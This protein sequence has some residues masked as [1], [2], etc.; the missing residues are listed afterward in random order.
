MEVPENVRKTFER[1]KLEYPYYIVLAVINGRFYVYKSKAWWDKK[2]KKVRSKKEYLGRI[3]ETGEFIKRVVVKAV[4]QPVVTSVP[5]YDFDKI[6]ESILMYLSMNCRI[7]LSA[8][9]NKLGVTLQTVER[10]KAELEERYGI[11]Y[12]ASINYTKLGFST[13][14]TL[15]K[16]KEKK[17]SAEVLKEV[18]ENEPRVQLAMVSTGVYDFILYILAEDNFIISNIIYK[19][20]SDERL[21]D[22]EA[23]W[24]T[25]IV[26][27]SY[28]Y[29]PITDRFF[30]LLEKKVW[31]RSKEVPRPASDSLMRLCPTNR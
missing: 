17:P 30:D 26:T 21:K 16:F 4:N 20:T 24:N 29:V 2:D 19:F 25:T 18:L 27:D 15:V 8:L 13:Y 23:D 10:R 28:G 11:R 5:T 22:Y 1:L 6:D 31:K 12:F 14:L 3:I 9:A 7:P